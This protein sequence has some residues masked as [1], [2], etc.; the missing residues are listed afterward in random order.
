MP[1]VS[2]KNLLETGVHFGHQTR[3]WDP[4]MSKYIF[5]Q[6][7]G[8][9]IIDLQRTSRKLEE[10]YWFVKEVSKSKG[11]FLFVGTKK[12]AQE[13]VKE[14]A[15]RSGAFF[16]NS[17]WLGGTLTN[18]LTIKQRIKRLEQLRTMEENGTFDLLPKKEV[19]KLKSEIERLERFIGGIKNM[20]KLPDAIFVVDTKKEQIA[21]EE[22]KKLKIPIV[23]M[24]DT[25]C[26]PSI[27][28][29]V[30]PAN[31]DAIRA[32]KLICDTIADAIIEGREAKPPAKRIIENQIPSSSS[33]RGLDKVLDYGRINQ[34]KKLHN[35]EILN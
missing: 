26:D 21:C 28:D 16:V 10:A 24:V 27:V 15:E 18:F 8:I 17:R 32:V 34:D 9:H 5:T 11:S 30:I 20:A 25:N 19:L 7:N 6:R 33:P 14:S 29:Y 1:I 35:E 13:S 23:G 4:R 12:Q 3:R 2:M 31:D 22:A